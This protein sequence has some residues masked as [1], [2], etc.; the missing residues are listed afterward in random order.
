MSNKTPTI[1]HLTVE[2]KRL[3]TAEAELWVIVRVEGHEESLELRG[4][5]VGPRCAQAETV[6][7]AYPLKSMRRPELGPDVRAGRFIIPEPNCW[8]PEMPFM[9]EGSVELWQAS[10]CV[11][12]RPIRAI[13]KA[14][15]RAGRPAAPAPR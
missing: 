6:Q 4:S 7:I 12:V 5:L 3:S 13:F 1:A 14:L 10:R 9:Y 15:D 11:D 8:T 2:Q